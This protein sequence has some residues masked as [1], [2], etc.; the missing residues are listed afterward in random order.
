MLMHASEGRRAI[1]AGG[2]GLK[3]AEMPSELTESRE[4]I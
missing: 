2:S 1:G 4:I 3:S